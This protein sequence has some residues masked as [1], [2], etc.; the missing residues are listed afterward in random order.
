M[1]ILFMIL[2]ICPITFEPLK[3]GGVCKKKKGC[4]SQAF[5]VVFVQSLE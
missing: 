4:N 2:F 5:Y 1:N 3:M